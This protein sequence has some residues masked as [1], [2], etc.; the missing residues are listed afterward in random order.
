MFHRLCQSNPVMQAR[1]HQARLLGPIRI[2][3][4]FSYYNRRFI[5][6]RLLRVGDAAG[7]IDPIFSAGVFLAMWSGK[8]AAQTVH[9][10]LRARNAKLNAIRLTRYEAKLRRA[11]KCYWRLVEHFYTT[12]FME[13]FLEPRNKWSLPAAVSAVLAGEL[14]GGWAVRW[15]LQVFYWLIRLQRFFPLVPRI[16][17]ADITGTPPEIDPLTPAN[18]VVPTPNFQSVTKPATKGASSPQ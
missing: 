5:G 1:M 8:L 4:D 15:R 6:P 11:M 13:I 17:L 9:H 16:P 2:T 7:F 3:S 10:S 14:E 12:P 18:P